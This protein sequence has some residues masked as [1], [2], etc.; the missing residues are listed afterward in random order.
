MKSKVLSCINV[1]VPTDHKKRFLNMIK[2]T[3]S[4]GTCYGMEIMYTCL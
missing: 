4:Y 3:T 1:H 2:F